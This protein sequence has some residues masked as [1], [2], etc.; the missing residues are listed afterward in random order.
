MKDKLQRNTNSES[1]F[2]FPDAQTRR[3]PHREEKEHKTSPSNSGETGSEGLTVQFADSVMH[4]YY[5]T[6]KADNTA[7]NVPRMPTD[8][9]CKTG[10]ASPENLSK[11]RDIDQKI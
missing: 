11:R 3:N 8:P 9:R 2:V 10:I 4:A 6:Y 5:P 7:H 1:S